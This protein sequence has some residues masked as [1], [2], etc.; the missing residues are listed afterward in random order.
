MGPTKP[1]LYSIFLLLLP[2]A[3]TQRSE[4]VQM[5]T[6]YNVR[7]SLRL[8]EGQFTFGSNANSDQRNQL[9]KR[10]LKSSDI[11]IPAQKAGYHAELSEL[12]LER[13]DTVLFNE[14][15]SKAVQLAIVHNDSAALA[16]SYYNLGIYFQRRM[17]NDSAYYHFS[18]AEKIYANQGDD[19]SSAK[20]LFNMAQ[21]QAQIRDYVGSEITVTAAIQKLKRLDKEDDLYYAYKLLGIV[22]GDLGDYDR[23]LENFNKAS[24]YL[25]ISSLDDFEELVLTNNIGVIY[26]KQ[27]EYVVAQTYYSKVLAFEGVFK[28]SPKLAGRTLSNLS[29]SV[30]NTGKI[31]GV[32][33]MLVK[34]SEI[35]DSIQDVYGKTGS[36]YNFGTYYLLQKD[37][38][39]ALLYFNEAKS[40]SKL[41]NNND[42]YLKTLLTISQLDRKNALGYTTEYIQLSDSLQDQERKIR[43][44]FAR[45]RFETNEVVA[46]NQQLARQRQLWTGIAGATALLGLAIFIIFT[47]RA[48]N[49]NLR[50]QQ[51]QQV[52]NQEIFDLMLAQ[53]EKL[54]EGKQIEQKRISEELHDGVQGRLQGARMLLLALNNK[55]DENSINERKEAI[56]LLKEIQEEVRSISHE[57][58]HAAYQKI[59]NFELFVDE[60]I[61]TIGKSGEVDIHL[62]F[63]NLLDWDSLNGDLKINLFRMVQEA[64]QNAVKHANCKKIMVDL[65]VEGNNIVTRIVDDGQGFVVKKGKNGIGMRNIASRIKK[66]S[67]TWSIESESG[68]G[69]TVNLIIPFNIDY[70]RDDNTANEES[71]ENI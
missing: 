11:L 53:S 21:I 17:V 66:L 70:G 25:K 7:D 1:V 33:G 22:A 41:V 32:S 5:V 26:E 31:D 37:T 50:F 52:A 14:L 48:K 71:L 36:S 38:T 57:L 6:D 12:F 47:L 51:A 24:G 40:L 27:K 42:R 55:T 30:L 58:S 9:E 54:E 15:N 59:H 8:W 44:K 62:N 4:P 39:R 67:G 46:Q 61:K 20:A 3:C 65:N 19:A 23:A 10:V 16:K 45:I 49:Q 60:Q 68:V 29:A 34:A 69:T 28:K 64:L 56:V 13:N 35:M 2:M 43:D 18:R 63:S